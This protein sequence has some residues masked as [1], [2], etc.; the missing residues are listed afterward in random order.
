LA[1][2]GIVNSAKS[3][4]RAA[5]RL[6]LSVRVFASTDHVDLFG[7][8]DFAS[9]RITR[10]G[11]MRQ[12][13]AVVGAVCILLSSVFA[14]A[15]QTVTTT[16]K[17]S[18]PPPAA[19]T[20]SGTTNY[21]PLWTSSSALGNS[22]MFQTGGLVGIGTTTPKYLLDV[23][24]YINAAKGY[25]I[26]ESVVLTMPGGSASG[27]N[28]FGVNGL[29]SATT[30]G[31]NTTVGSFTLSVN[32][33]G[34]RNSVLGYGAL[35]N[36]TT[37]GS[38]TAVGEEALSDNSTG[39]Q[40]TALGSGSLAFTTGSNNIGIGYDGG[41]FVAAGN[42]SIEIGN[43]GS[44]SDNGIIR[45]GTVG[46][47]SAFFAAGIYGA[48]AGN[49]DAIPVLVDS[50]GQLVTTPSSRRYK[51]DIQDMGDASSGLLRLRPVTFRYQKPLADGSQ[52]K[53]YGLIAE[54]V[55]EVYPD[56]VAHS[57]DGQIETVKYQVL[58]S[59]LLNEVQRQQAEI[60]ELQERLSRMEA[61]LAAKP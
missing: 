35:F 18:A 2:G 53:Q 16:P 15:Q 27:N 45:I 33:T 24:G 30:G 13:H 39:G 41:Q 4:L 29:A 48:S 21:I 55:A 3:G 19:V 47:Q 1:G 23:N 22:K 37:G 38:N 56:L 49:N 17:A 46:T 52:P 54:E 9:V 10:G 57:S 31:F 34:S 61:A 42:S 28:S 12:A 11:D 20:G 8:G 40:N 44:S 25:L 6:C 5:L 32:T 51:T 14:Q 43:T 58:D 7:I 59:M 60:K 26:G 36:N 50:S